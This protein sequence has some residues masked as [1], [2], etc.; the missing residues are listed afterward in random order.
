MTIVIGTPSEGA[1]S[2]YT[3][4]VAELRDQQDNA[5]YSQEAIDRALRK[6]ESYALRRLRV[7]EQEISTTLAI[8]EGLA[9]LPTDCR[10]IRAVLWDAG[11]GEYML[12]NVDPGTLQEQYGSGIPLAYAREGNTL[13]LSPTTTGTARIVYYAGLTPLS[14]DYPTNWLLTTAPDLYIAGALYYLC[15]RE[16][17]MAGAQMALSEADAIIRALNEE[18]A[19]KAGGNMV[20][21][22]IMQVRGANA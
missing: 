1:I 22:G 9:T 8:T 2:N 4:I 5:V 7:A 16:R 21:R 20:P 14:Q 18:T 19:Y 15:R 10:Q 6:A 13:R 11:G 3:Q 17:D 12:A